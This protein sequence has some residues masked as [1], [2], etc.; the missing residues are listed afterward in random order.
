M[1]DPE[2]LRLRKSSFTHEQEILCVLLNEEIL[3]NL[4]SSLRPTFLILRNGDL[5]VI[6]L[7]IH[8]TT[9]R[10]MRLFVLESWRCC[11]VQS[12]QDGLHGVQAV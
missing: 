1:Y 9:V 10:R 5:G 3:K 6:A 7:G 2:F 8:T 4:H 11:T 12:P